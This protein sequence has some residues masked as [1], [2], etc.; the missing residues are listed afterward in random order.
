MAVNNVDLRNIFDEQDA[1][2]SGGQ[3]APSAPGLGSRL[4]TN[5]KDSAIA[6]AD[7]TYSIFANAATMPLNLLA[8]GVA[9]IGGLFS[10]I[11]QPTLPQSNAEKSLGMAPK[12]DWSQ[13]VQLNLDQ[14]MKNIETVQGG[15]RKVTG[16]YTPEG[17][18]TLGNLFKP[19]EWLDKGAQA[20]GDKVMDMTGSPTAG[21]LTA[22]A[23]NASP[24]LI[25]SAVKSVKAGVKGIKEARDLSKRMRT[26]PERGLEISK[27]RPTWEEIQQANPGMSQGELLRKYPAYKDE[28]LR[29]R[30]TPENAPTTE[31]PATPATPAPD[32]TFANN[33]T[34][35]QRERVSR[36]VAEL[37]SVEAVKKAYPKA[38]LLGLHAYAQTLAQAAEDA[39]IFVKPEAPVDTSVAPVS[40]A[41]DTPL[42]L[43]EPPVKPVRPEV[44]E[45]PSGPVIELGDGQQLTKAP[46]IQQPADE[47]PQVKISEPAVEPPEVKTKKP[48]T[49]N[50]QAKAALESSG[51]ELMTKNGAEFWKVKLSNGKVAR[52]P[53]DGKNAHLHAQEEIA[54]YEQLIAED[55]SLQTYA[56]DKAVTDAGLKLNPR[57]FDDIVAA[58]NFMNSAADRLGDGELSLARVG[59]SVRI[60]EKPAVDPFDL[61]DDISLDDA[62]DIDTQHLGDVVKDYEQADLTYGKKI[63]IGEVIKTQTDELAKAMTE[64]AMSREERLARIKEKAEAMQKQKLSEEDELKKLIEE[65]DTF[66]EQLYDVEE[67]QTD[68]ST[69]GDYYDEV[70]V[71]E[72]RSRKTIRDLTD[73]FSDE[74]GAVGKDIS[75]LPKHF[76]PLVKQRPLR[77]ILADIKTLIHSDQRGALNP[78]RLDPTT[79]M[80]IKQAKDRLVSDASQI[81]GLAKEIS[82]QISLFKHFATDKDGNVVKLY[83]GTS[84]VYSEASLDRLGKAT[85]A[86]SARLGFFHAANPRTAETYTHYSDLQ[87]VTTYDSILKS[88]QEE[89]TDADYIIDWY[90]DDDAILVSLKQQMK[91]FEIQL[92]ELYNSGLDMDDPSV[93][94][95][96]EQVRPLDRQYQRR[97]EE[98]ADMP[99]NR[100]RIDSAI[101]AEAKWMY[102]DVNN[103]AYNAAADKLV[104]SDPKY[105]MFTELRNDA[106]NAFIEQAVKIKPLFG[107]ETTVLDIEQYFTDRTRFATAEDVS[108]EPQMSEAY[109]AWKEKRD[110]ITRAKDY[111]FKFIENIPFET[112]KDMIDGNRKAAPNIRPS[113]LKMKKPYVYDMKGEHYREVSYYEIIKKAWNNGH[114][115]VIIRNTYDG[116][117]LDDIYVV[118]EPH[119]IV[120]AFDMDS[121]FVTLAKKVFDKISDEGGFINAEGSEFVSGLRRLGTW[122][123]NAFKRGMET[124]R[125]LFDSAHKFTVEDRSKLANAERELKA[126]VAKTQRI[127]KQLGEFSPGVSEELVKVQRG[128]KDILKDLNTALGERGAIGEQPKTQAQLEAGQRLLEDLNRISNETKAKFTKA[129]KAKR[130]ADATDKQSKGVK[131]SQEEVETIARDLTQDADMVADAFFT[132]GQGAVD[133]LVAQ[134]KLNKRI[135]PRYK[136]GSFKI[137]DRQ[138]PFIPKEMP[139]L[140]DDKAD[141]MGM[142]IK[143]VRSTTGHV[144]TPSFALRPFFKPGTSPIIDAME[145]VMSLNT[146]VRNAKSWKSDVFGEVKTAK[147]DIDKVLTPLYNR[148]QKMMEVKDGLDLELNR[149]RMRYKDARKLRDLNRKR[150]ASIKADNPKAKLYKEEYVK[151][152]LDMKKYNEQAK[153]ANKRRKQISTAIKSELFGGYDKEIM[154]LAQK[155]PVVRITLAAGDKLPLGITLSET[156]AALADT[157]SDFFEDRAVHLRKNKIATIESRSFMSHMFGVIATDKWATKFKYEPSVPTRFKF[158]HQRLDSRIWYPDLHVILDAYIPLVERKL[159]FQPFLDRWS[160]FIEY[161]AP[162]NMRAMMV[163]WMKA[164]LYRR[165]GGFVNAAMDGV[166]AVEYARLVAFSLSIALKHATKLLDTFATNTTTSTLYGAFQTAKLPLQ[167]IAAAIG[168]RGPSPEMELFKAYVSLDQMVKLMDEGPG[169]KTFARGFKLIGGSFT[170]TTEVIDNGVTIFANALASKQANLTTNQ[171]TQ[172]IWDAILRANFRGGPD[173]P[174][175]MKTSGGRAAFMFQTTRQKVTELRLSVIK[176]FVKGGEDAYG[177]NKRFRLLRYM[178]AVGAVTFLARQDDVDILPWFVEPPWVQEF[179]HGVSKEPGYAISE[180]KP[181]ISPV[182]DLAYAWGEKG[183]KGIVDHYSYSAP[184]KY[185]QIMDKDYPTPYYDS[186]LK[187]ALGLRKIDAGHKAEKRTDLRKRAGR[188]GIPKRK[189]R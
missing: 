94:A 118:K 97:I 41:V 99:E 70:E 57:K 24:L 154:A 84:R 6:A 17:E 181:S 75:K 19:F 18:R 180:P 82:K 124:L 179:L 182:I 135:V 98:L 157:L 131:L 143:G 14:A 142:E 54:K 63:D 38:D 176:D 10:G 5:A 53:A 156:E 174:L 81:I 189:L 173:M 61:E 144:L 86:P 130:K 183:V 76:E 159:A 123:K 3:T 149:Y 95:I 33:L 64:K 114:D 113:Y 145:S 91:E 1:G 132:K 26:I 66:D 151:A 48:R 8:S 16:P 133:A 79:R 168:L 22:T 138:I 4:L 32:P 139:E 117:P 73:I 172:L 106:Y 36:H 72:K 141:L 152:E 177:K 74:R 116:G 20:A 62:P 163:D 171:A 134:M 128:F 58:K 88:V 46:A 29:A 68:R 96:R 155:H 101:E 11:E 31:A 140:L 111:Y 187:Q 167:A 153:A 77:E 39:G 50:Q 185:V 52:I 23:I 34:P 65:T 146:N 40:P 160:D 9:G 37:G 103:D 178:A 67:M 186:P 80:K 126:T 108:I 120:P 59:N 12:P 30:S 107:P 162:T 184:Y 71:I 21:A 42:G 158:K 169:L 44:T 55:S 92:S 85:D 25:P 150:L 45:L 27:N 47:V 161:K 2:T 90:G 112:I 15:F 129:K 164:N 69:D 127:E 170:T 104:Y 7:Q 87:D 137:P 89:S 122:I 28:A 13:P 56:S 43:P 109:E 115:G 93:S 175:Y 51:A 102:K 148:V 166:V 165:E 119:Q 49:P 35:K 121:R 60:V 125:A 147:A 100:N 188:K 105:L 136:K 110:L 83:H 78:E